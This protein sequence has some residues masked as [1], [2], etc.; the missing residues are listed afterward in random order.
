MGVRVQGSGFGHPGGFGGF[1]VQGLCIISGSSGAGL[2]HQKVLFE[3][4]TNAV[5][6]AAV[7]N[8]PLLVLGIL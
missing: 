5:C 8:K 2:Q 3:V 7:A 1:G 6:G 4:A